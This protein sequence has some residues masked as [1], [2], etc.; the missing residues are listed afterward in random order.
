LVGAVHELAAITGVPA[1]NTGALLG[2]TR[3]MARQ[4]GLYART[5]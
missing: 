4:R 5:T 2:M 1:P 3:L